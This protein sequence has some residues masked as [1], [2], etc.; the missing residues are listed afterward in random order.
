MFGNGR[1]VKLSKDVAAQMNDVEKQLDHIA[2]CLLDIEQHLDGNQESVDKIIK[3]T[4]QQN[5]E[6]AK[7]LKDNA[8]ELIGACK[9]YLAKRFVPKAT[10]KSCWEARLIRISSV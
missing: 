9:E 7:R 10:K 2:I 6:V 4:K 5:E 3:F 8:K 1:L